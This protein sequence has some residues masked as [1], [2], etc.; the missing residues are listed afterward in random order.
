MESASQQSVSDAPKIHK[1][2]MEEIFEKIAGRIF[3][4]LAS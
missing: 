3:E 2:K 4:I 1:T